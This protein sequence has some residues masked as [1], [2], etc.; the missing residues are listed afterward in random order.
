MPNNDKLIA[1]SLGLKP[2]DIII[3]EMP[4]EDATEEDFLPEI[5][6]EDFLPNHVAIWTGN[7]F[8]KPLAHSVY[9]GYKLPGIRLTSIG[10]GQHLV[11]RLA[12]SA[13]ASR[14]ALIARI[15]AIGSSQFNRERFDKVYPERFWNSRENY[16]QH[17]LDFFSIPNSTTPG[18]ATPYSFER[19]SQQLHDRARNPKL[20][21]FT[22][23]SLRRA[24]KFSS[25][26]ELIAPISNGMRCSSF[27]ISVIQA[28][29]LSEITKKTLIK[30]SFK[31]FRE[32]DF[33]DFATKVLNSE[34]QMSQTGEQLK[35]AFEGKNY[36]SL[37]PGGTDIDS[38]FATPSDIWSAVRANSSDWIFLGSVSIYLQKI[39]HLNVRQEQSAHLLTTASEISEENTQLKSEDH[40]KRRINLFCTPPRIQTSAARKAASDGPA[41]SRVLF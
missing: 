24:I 40:L 21:Q 35:S 11:F 6:P 10:D 8:S 39:L 14:V 34:W 29:V 16:Q 18:P 25:R 32:L 12:N 15:W 3:T 20:I 38:K 28:A 31:P 41:R 33:I 23:S 2:G 36:A 26:S 13:L 4:Y 1:S 17:K 37:F 9:E 5:N 27:V 22:E 30:T 7:S 19:A